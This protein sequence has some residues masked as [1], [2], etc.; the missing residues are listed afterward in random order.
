MN[1][2]YERKKKHLEIYIPR[3]IITIFR[4]YLSIFEARDYYYHGW[5]RAMRIR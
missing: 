3:L 4:V 1:M 5:D 2:S